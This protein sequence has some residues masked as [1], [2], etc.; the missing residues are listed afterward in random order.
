M[1]FHPTARSEVNHRRY[2]NLR[3]ESYATLGRRLD[4]NDIQFKDQPFA[5]PIDDRVRR[6]LVVTERKVSNDMIRFHIEPK[7]EVKKKLKGRS[8]EV[9]DSITILFWALREVHDLNRYFMEHD[10]SEDDADTEPEELDFDPEEYLRDEYGIEPD[11]TESEGVFDLGEDD[12][13][14]ETGGEKGYT[15]L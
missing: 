3:C 1:E 15:F 13:D 6:E 7:E 5:L 12:D 9:A 11:I 8:P 4:P 10:P 14:R 2:A